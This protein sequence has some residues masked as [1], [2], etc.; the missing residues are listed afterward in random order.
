L[1]AGA[2]APLLYLPL[3]YLFLPGVF[4]REYFRVAPGFWKWIIAGSALTAIELVLTQDAAPMANAIEGLLFAPIL[5]E[6]MRAVIMIPVIDAWGNTLSIV[7]ATA[8]MAALHP[9]PMYAIL[10]QLLLSITFIYS[11]K[12]IATASLTHLAINTTVAGAALLTGK[13]S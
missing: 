13:L 9:F 6:I 8:L 5:E 7:F 11:R 12:S 3:S 10:G 4:N 2:Y 1:H